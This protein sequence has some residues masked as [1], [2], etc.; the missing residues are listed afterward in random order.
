VVLVEGGSKGTVEGTT[1][2]HRPLD[3]KY[4]ARVAIS[5][6]SIKYL[7]AFSLSI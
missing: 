3:I 1:G 6:S 5:V 2:S 7:G 4:D